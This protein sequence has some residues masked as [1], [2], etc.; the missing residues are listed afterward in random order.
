MRIYK[1]KCIDFESPTIK[2][3][4]KL[5]PVSQKPFEIQT[6]M[7]RFQM[8]RFQIPTVWTLLSRSQMLPFNPFWLACKWSGLWI[9]FEFN[10]LLDHSKSRLDQIQDPH[11]NHHVG[12]R[13]FPVVQEVFIIQ[14]M[15]ATSAELRSRET[16]L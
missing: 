12:N 6:K 9:P 4:D 13:C 11:R 1:K 7:S 2:N 14:I 10:P 5:L 15:G 3:P 16:L 8:V